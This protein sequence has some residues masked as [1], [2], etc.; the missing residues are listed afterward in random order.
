MRNVL[1]IDDDQDFL[2]VLS[3]ALD[4]YGYRSFTAYSLETT[5]EK[6]AYCFPDIAV[7]DIHLGKQ[8]GIEIIKFLKN[9]HPETKIVVLS[10]YAN[11]PSAV[12]VIKA[13]ADECVPKPIE[14]EELDFLFRRLYGERVSMP[15][16]STSPN[17]I[18]QT[19]ILEN[20]EKNGGNIS[21]TA[22]KLGMHRRTLQRIIRKAQSEPEILKH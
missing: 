21:E 11:I 2:R 20:L 16:T 6:L 22:R 3:R 8:S 19:H 7:V 10:G 12:A 13:G 14:V 17:E 18:R 5:I 9:Y 1:I 4:K 15:K